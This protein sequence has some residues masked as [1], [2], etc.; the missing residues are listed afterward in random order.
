MLKIVST[1]FPYFDNPSKTKTRPGLALTPPLGKYNL[2]IVLFM[3]TQSDDVL[4]TDVVIETDH[5]QF[6]QTGLK[7]KTFIKLH[8]I[9]AIVDTDIQSELGV[10][11]EE[12]EK[13]VAEKLRQLFAL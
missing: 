1:K 4:P 11:P 13:E 2:V 7:R 10:I 8:K 12:H 6:T 9:T 3:T 5:I